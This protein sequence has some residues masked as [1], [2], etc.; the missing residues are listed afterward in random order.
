MPQLRQNLATK[1]W[2]VISTE[3]AR[4]PHSLSELQ[5][6]QP[7]DLPSYDP[8]CPFCA[9]EERPGEVEV[10]RL[11]ENGPWQVRIV[12]NRYPALAPEGDLER[13]F[14]GVERWMTGLGYHEIVIEG[15]RHDLS[16]A[17]ADSDMLYL[18]LLAFQRRG[19]MLEQDRRMVYIQYFKNHGAAAGASLDHPHSQLIALP[20]VPGTRRQRAEEARRYCDER[21]GCVFCAMLADELRLQSRLVAVNESAAAFVLYAALSPFHIWV[22]PRRHLANF[23]EA[24]PEDIRAV[25]VCLHQ[26]L[27]ALDRGLNNPAYNY[28][29]HSCPLH[30]C[31]REYLHWYITVVARISTM[32]GFEM[33]TGMYIN[34]TLPEESAA[35]LA[36][37][38]ADYPS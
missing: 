6:C 37:I 2:V 35:F 33:G 14:S 20:V 19:L 38:L 18:T 15:P 28:V 21:G 24:E 17:R 27:W 34:P 10:L 4:R 5:P 13:H 25:A 29:L 3:R 32:A 23:L 1:Q 7:P 30:D 31:G 26:V 36:H 22:L 9:P 11:P 8:R 12:R 16:P